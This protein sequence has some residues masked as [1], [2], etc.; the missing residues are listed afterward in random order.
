VVEGTKG[1]KKTYMTLLERLTK[2]YI[3]IEMQE[4]TNA[5]IKK[6]IHSLDE[7]YGKYFKKIFKSM[8]TDNGH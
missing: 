5:C 8:T 1:S 6:A 2:K 3:V 4:H 7:K